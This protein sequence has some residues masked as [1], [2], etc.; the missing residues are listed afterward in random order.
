MDENTDF[1][2]LWKDYLVSEI[3]GTELQRRK[4]ALSLVTK[5]LCHFQCGL[6]PSYEK[7]RIV[8][9]TIADVMAAFRNHLYSWSRVL[10]LEEIGES[11][12]EGLNNQVYALYTPTP[13]DG[14]QEG[15]SGC[16]YQMVTL[17]DLKV[18]SGDPS[19][20]IPEAESNTFQVKDNGR[21]IYSKK[22]VKIP[23]VETSL[24]RTSADKMTLFHQR[25]SGPAWITTSIVTV[26]HSITIS[27]MLNSSGV[28][29][30]RTEHTEGSAVR[31][32]IK[33]TPTDVA[34]GNQKLENDWHV[35][36]ITGP[37]V[38]N[39]K[40]ISDRE[41]VVL[42][43]PQTFYWE[44]RSSGSNDCVFAVQKLFDADHAFFDVLQGVGNVDK[45][46]SI[47]VIDHC[48]QIN[49]NTDV[50]L[51][52]SDGKKYKLCMK[53]GIFLV[54]SPNKKKLDWEKLIGGVWYKDLSKEITRSR[55][56][57]ITASSTDPGT[58]RIGKG[59]R[60][61]L[62]GDFSINESG[63]DHLLN[64][65]NKN[66]NKTDRVEI[67]G[68]ATVYYK[69]KGNKEQVLFLSMNERI[70]FHAA[71][72]PRI[73]LFKGDF[74]GEELNSYIM[75][76]INN[77][78]AEVQRL[79]EELRSRENASFENCISEESGQDEVESYSLFSDVTPEREQFRL[80][81]DVDG[82]DEM[83][84]FQVALLYCLNKKEKGI[85]EAARSFLKWH[86]RFATSDD[87]IG[88]HINEA[89]QR[90]LPDNHPDKDKDLKDYP[91][92]F[93][94]Y[95]NSLIT[96]LNKEFKDLIIQVEIDGKKTK[97]TNRR[98]SLENK[99]RVEVIRTQ[100]RKAASEK[101]CNDS[102]EP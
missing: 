33:A 7:D 95:M 13:I 1:H 54:K 56:I 29:F 35:M 100:W 96:L 49:D 51:I 34:V 68:P 93:N 12:D 90:N 78:L 60:S 101:L 22:G 76:Y 64:Y 31:E 39:D 47:N 87:G 40:E 99:R 50:H 77:K 74:V 48:P 45:F 20:I 2:N 14:A 84:D 27:P 79:A 66:I 8:M 46:V 97:E 89:I 92:L 102:K 23:V 30:W 85:S 3:R 61:L 59:E 88:D 11:N 80:P 65:K 10:L 38:I 73:Q 5:T 67:Q 75:G 36:Y 21:S 26:D 28:A 37:V 4:A 82:I 18:E 63:S 91:K 94:R 24:K 69:G 57:R 41:R 42:I 86:F 83:S 98:L 52:K 15:D 6:I 53:P 81:L 70:V 71:K 16:F 55:L 17:K 9:D 19:T 44:E 72:V 32:A 58:I 62:S 25:L 43:K